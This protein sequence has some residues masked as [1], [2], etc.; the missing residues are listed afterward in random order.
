MPPIGKMALKNLREREK[1][2]GLCGGRE[3][4]ARKLQDGG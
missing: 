3:L 4:P 2:K 1:K